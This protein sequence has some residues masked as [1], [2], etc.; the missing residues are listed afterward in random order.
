MLKYSFVP[1][2]ELSCKKCEELQVYSVIKVTITLELK[3][4]LKL[5]HTSFGIRAL[6]CISFCI[7]SL[8]ACIYTAF[9]THQNTLCK[10]GWKS[11]ISVNP[12]FELCTCKALQFAKQCFLR[13]PVV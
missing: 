9:V 3:L 13:Q 6:G 4:Y 5:W 2:H 12:K 8:V 11:I 1:S 7:D 10:Y